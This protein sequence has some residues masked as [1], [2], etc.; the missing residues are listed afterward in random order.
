[1][2]GHL[3]TVG[4]LSCLTSSHASFWQTRRRCSLFSH[5]FVLL[6]LRRRLA[7]LPW[8]ITLISRSTWSSYCLVAMRRWGL[9]RVR[10]R[11]ILSSGTM[12]SWD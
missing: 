3:F 11:A 5:N 4:I 8:R 2:P 1:M 6:P 10:V 7:S 12:W 9:G